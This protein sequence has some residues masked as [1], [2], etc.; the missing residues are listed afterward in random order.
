MK[1]SPPAR[2]FWLPGPGEAL[3]LAMI[4][5]MMGSLALSA[6]Q[7][8]ARVVN[9]FD[10]TLLAL[11]AFLLSLEGIASDRLA[12][13][14]P[15]ASVRLRLHLG[16]WVVL[17]AALRLVLSLSQGPGQ[18]AADL[19]RWLARPQGL[20][21]GGL[22][23]AGAWLAATWWLGIQMGR[24]L[25]AL[26]P[27]AEA[28]P[29]KD[30]AA[31]YAWLTRPLEDRPGE[32]RER[33]AQLVFTGGLLL[34]LCSGLARLDIGLA[35]SL[36]HPAMAGIVGNALLYFA[37]AFVLLARGHYAALQ[38]RWQ[39]QE[40][41]VA[42]PLGRR[43]AV[44]ALAFAVAVAAVALLLPVRPSLALF[45]AAFGILWNILL[46][47]EQALML[48]MAAVGYL[49]HLLLQLLGL[50][51]PAAQAPVAPP[52]MPA[53]QPQPQAT[54]AG[55]WQ[56]LQSLLLWALI[57][58]AVVYALIHFVRDRRGL[59]AILLARGG[60]LAWAAR[61]VEAV[62]RWLAGLRRSAGTRWRGWTARWRP[63]APAQAVHRRLRWP[64][65]RDAR[66]H[67]RLL[68]L[69]GLR[70]TARAGLGRT[71]AETPY[72]YARRAW[73]HL[74]EGGEELQRMT[75]AFVAA[76]YSPRDPAP[77]QV[78]PLRQAYRRLRRACRRLLATGPHS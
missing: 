64:R 51:S 46:L 25:E 71:P 41:P 20:V 11:L 59:W 34:L 49:L 3:H 36:R 33:L 13:Q 35:L 4:A 60:P 72:E 62:A 28:P 15:E 48:A 32:A 19:P 66:E 10:P 9:G 58:G 27:Q 17:V 78:G 57:V 14:F 31:F 54:A 22:V 7:L 23:V 18:L 43:W 50:A 53:P 2:P 24:C 55:W 70:E 67:I 5:A 47:G 16:E 12:R 45:G 6:G 56:A 73:P 29:P 21:D 1:P 39:R 61:L 40:V 65:P 69:L 75:E 8:A 30:S 37:L 52:T 38:A 74:A 68:Y 44:L 63:S 76:R 77:S 26:G 42:G